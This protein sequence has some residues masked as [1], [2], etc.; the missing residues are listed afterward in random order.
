MNQLYNLKFNL[1]HKIAVVLIA[2]SILLDLG[3]PQLV[4]AEAKAS[5]LPKDQVNSL[6]VAGKRLPRKVITAVVTA[7]S[8]TVDQTDDDPFMAA[9]GPVYD[10]MVAV[11]W[12]P[13]CTKVRFPDLYGDKIFSVEDRMN[14][15]YGYGRV[16]IWMNAPRPQVDNFGVQRLKMEIY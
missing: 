11:N 13:F 9:N 10:G 5:F 7:Y 2:L 16:D 1:T 4:V 15:K 12:L 6:P 8:S 14:A 3:Y